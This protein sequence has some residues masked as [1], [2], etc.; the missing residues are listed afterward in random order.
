MYSLVLKVHHEVD[1]EVTQ[2]RYVEKNVTPLETFCHTGRHLRDLTINM[3]K[4]RG[5]QPLH[6]EA[7]GT[8]SYFCLPS[9]FLHPYATCC[10]KFAVACW[11]ARLCPWHPKKN[12]LAVSSAIDRFKFVCVC[13]C[14]CE[15]LRQEAEA[16][17]LA[18]HKTV[19]HGTERHHQYNRGTLSQSLSVSA[20]W[21]AV[22]N[23]STDWER[24]C[25][26]DT[27]LASLFI[28]S[29]CKIKFHT[30]SWCWLEIFAARPLAGKHN[31]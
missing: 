29:F 26:R 28:N 9:A 15:F 4:L 12:Q 2:G 3:C 21:L 11:R 14:L 8:L 19:A 16:F 7:F 25:A 31:E 13:A 6:L 5:S 10:S 22:Y 30:I 24:L 18:T 20:H 27:V 23:N 1:F 17:E